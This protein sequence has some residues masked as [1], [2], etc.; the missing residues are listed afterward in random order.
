[1]KKNIQN[2]IVLIFFIV[3]ILIIAGISAFTV[4]TLQKMSGTID[5]SIPIRDLLIISAIALVLYILITIVIK[6]FVSKSVVKPINRLIESAEKMAKG[7]NMEMSNI[8]NEKTEVDELVNAF[9]LM[10]RE[11]NQ[12]LTE[13]NRQK[14]Q[15]ETILLHM[16]DGVIAFDMNGEI[17]HINPAAKTLLGLT[18]K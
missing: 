1:M 17:I 13:V 16:T 5:V 14:K 8:L 9:N 15:I 2:K 10:T 3:G 12:K 4:Y 18:D 6:Y 11:L 7:Q